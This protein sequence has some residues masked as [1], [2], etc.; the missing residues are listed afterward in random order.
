M[1]IRVDFTGYPSNH[2][3]GCRLNGKL[4]KRSAIKKPDKNIKQQVCLDL[5]TKLLLVY[6]FRY[7]KG[8]LKQASSKI[9]ILPRIESQGEV[10][11]TN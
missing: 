3:S 9:K 1:K 11:G 6:D 2:L 8:I 7:V 10:E 5:Y 4:Q